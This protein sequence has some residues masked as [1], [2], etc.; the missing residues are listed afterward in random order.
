MFSGKMPISPPN[1]TTGTTTTRALQMTSSGKAIN[2]CI[3]TKRSPTPPF[4]GVPFPGRVRNDPLGARG[5][6]MVNLLQEGLTRTAADYPARRSHRWLRHKTRTRRCAL[7][8]LRTTPLRLLLEAAN[9][10]HSATLSVATTKTTGKTRL[11]T[12]C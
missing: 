12:R 9:F 2:T 6:A 10:R 7:Q 8:L 3:Q 11:L 4:I 1:S 5:S